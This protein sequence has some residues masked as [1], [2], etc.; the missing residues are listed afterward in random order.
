MPN[1]VRAV[2]RSVNDTDDVHR[3]ANTATTVLKGLGHLQ[4][5]GVNVQVNTFLASLPDDMRARLIST[6]QVVENTSEET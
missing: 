1:Y 5:D 2:E 4:N 6:P 3:A